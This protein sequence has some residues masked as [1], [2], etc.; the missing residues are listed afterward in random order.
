MAAHDGAGAAGL[1]RRIGGEER[2][3]A[4]GFRRIGRREGVVER[5]AQGLGPGVGT[6]LRLAGRARRR[7]QQRGSRLD[8][9]EEVA[10]ALKRV[11]ARR[12]AAGSGSR[13][14]PEPSGRGLQDREIPELVQ[15]P[16]RA[17]RLE[18]H[19]SGLDFRQRLLEL[20]EQRGIRDLLAA[21]PHDDPEIVTI[22][23]SG[24]PAP[25]KVGGTVPHDVG[26][27][28]DDPFIRPNWYRFQDV[29]GWKDLGPKFVLQL[30][31][32]AVVAD[33]AVGDALIAEAWPTVV[34]VL[35]AVAAADREWERSHSYLFINDVERR[36]AKHLGLE[37]EWFY[38]PR[39][40]VECPGCGEKI[41]P[42]VAVCKTCGAILDREKAA[43]LGLVR[44]EPVEAAV[45][46]TAVEVGKRKAGFAQQR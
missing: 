23:A 26:G 4:A 15:A 10:T 30:W 8:Q 9:G 44:H 11:H 17:R 5:G 43:A 19:V 7:D 25:R 35:R 29:N 28:H 13:N 36:A 14:R 22:E 1:K 3:A 12:L 24:V 20:H 6:G 27:P 33:P 46:A 38:Q 39:E 32:D 42:G 16:P 45:L 34:S 2:T 21:I 31:R 41:K 40:T 37:K 18:R